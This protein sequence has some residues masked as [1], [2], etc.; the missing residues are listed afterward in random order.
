MGQ[1]KIQDPTTGKT[2]TVEGD[3]APSQTDAEQ[4][5]HQAGLRGQSDASQKSTYEYKGPD[6]FGL[7]GSVVSAWVRSTRAQSSFEQS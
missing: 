2:V 6:V 1:Y 5:F 3:K 7:A 4:I